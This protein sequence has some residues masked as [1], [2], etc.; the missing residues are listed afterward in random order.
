MPE[1]EG[2]NGLRDQLRFLR[3]RRLWNPVTYR[4]KCAVA[5]ASVTENQERRGTLAEAFTLIRTSSFPTHRREPL[6]IRLATDSRQISCTGKPRLDPLRNSAAV[7]G[8]EDLLP[9]RASAGVVGS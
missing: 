4:A 3:V 5:R 1:L 2:D 6:C 8:D 7:C 9:R